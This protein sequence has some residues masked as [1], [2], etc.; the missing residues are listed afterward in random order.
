MARRKVGGSFCHFWI[1]SVD[2]NEKGRQR[3]RNQIERG[4][5]KTRERERKIF[6]AFSTVEARRSKN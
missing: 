4:E 1:N 6:P 3:G 2:E 5:R